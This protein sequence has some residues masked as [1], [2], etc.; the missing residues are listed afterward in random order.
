MDCY[1]GRF[2]LSKIFCTNVPLCYGI[3]VIGFKYKCDSQKEMSICVEQNFNTNLN[4]GF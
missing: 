1:N 2:G 3:I 4:Y